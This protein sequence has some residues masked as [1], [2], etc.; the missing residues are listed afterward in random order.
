MNM[1]FLFD[2]DNIVCFS[3][4]SAVNICSRNFY[5]HYVPMFVNLR[6][7]IWKHCVK[8][9]CIILCHTGLLC[10]DFAH[11]NLL[12]SVVVPTAGKAEWFHI[13]VLTI[14]LWLLF[15]ICLYK[16]A[17]TNRLLFNVCVV[18]PPSVS[19][20]PS[21][22][23]FNVH[24][25]ATDVLF[26]TVNSLLVSMYFIMTWGQRA[27]FIKQICH[28]YLKFQCVLMLWCNTH[29]YG[30]LEYCTQKPVTCFSD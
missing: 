18:I 4:Q 3:G 13:A 16:Q 27:I 15:S 23:N 21:V 8:L 1:Q 25:Q 11:W 9:I 2:G 6:F 5:L 10:T 24:R 7:C 26:L 22:S 12:T 28:F 17:D 29:F 20:C 19:V 14:L 30:I